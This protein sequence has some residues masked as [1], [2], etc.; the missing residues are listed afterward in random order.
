MNFSNILKDYLPYKSIISGYSR[1]PISVEGVTES[2]QPQLIYSLAE[3]NGGSALIITYTDIEAR[4]VRDEL[5]LYFKNTV[6]FPSKD[7]IFYNIETTGHQSENERLDVIAKLSEGNTIVTA[8]VDALMQYTLPK[9][10]FTRGCID[11][12]IGKVFDIDE[13]AQKLLD[14]GYSREEMVEGE[15]QFA[16]RGGILDVYSPNYPNPLR[17]E[18]FDNETDSIREFDSYTQRSL[19]KLGNARIIPVS[20]MLFSSKRRN[21]ISAELKSRLTADQSK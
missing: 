5:K 20:E 12:E 19:D 4:T 6:T 7:Y 11:F 1:T 17:I 3:N 21:E 16:I 13:L 14:I 15:G 18:F 2:A 9:D 8:S 10:I